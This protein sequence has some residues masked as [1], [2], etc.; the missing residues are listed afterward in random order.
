MRATLLC[1]LPCWLHGALALRMCTTSLL[2][3]RARAPPPR[4]GF[5]VE[6]VSEKAVGEMGVMGWPGL[7]K[8]QEDFSQRANPDELLMVYVKAGGA[9]LSDGEERATVSAGQMVMVSNGEVQWTDLEDGGLTL[10]STTTTLSDV[11][12]SEDAA[13]ETTLE[14]DDPVQDMTP[15][16]AALLLAAGLAAGS[17]A[18]FGFNTFNSVP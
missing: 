3:H 7:E 9:T 10:I 18:S 12:E 4:L 14:K 13:T 5:E 15:K 8:R 1:L 6:D 16:D 17:L 2:P 11:V